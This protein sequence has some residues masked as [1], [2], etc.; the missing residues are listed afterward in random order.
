MRRPPAAAVNSPMP[1]RRV[2]QRRGTAI[3]IAIVALVL[4]SAICF[5][6]VRITLSAV[7][8]ADRQQWRRQSLWLAESALAQAAEQFRSA[9]DFS[10][11]SWDVS[12]PDSSGELQGRI[13]WNVTPAGTNERE[14]VITATAEFPRHPTDRVRISRTLTLNLP[15]NT[16]AEPEEP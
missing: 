7:E 4:V 5:S 2:A 11:D 8:Q 10:G 15:Q 6:L 9:A 14:R 3:I 12:L 1:G 13:E 16:P